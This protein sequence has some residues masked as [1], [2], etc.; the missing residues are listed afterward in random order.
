MKHLAL[1][2][3]I[4][5]KFGRPWAME[6]AMKKELQLGKVLAALTLFAVLMLPTVVQFYHATQGCEHSSE[7]T[8]ATNLQQDVQDCH[9]CDFQLNSFHTATTHYTDVVVNTV[10]SE[11][12]TVYSAVQLNAYT[13]TNT[14]LRAPPYSLS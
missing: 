11:K 2:H 10:P 12:V 9:I 7:I 1:V 5:A 6:F 8:S 4:L 13:K 3:I 14:Q